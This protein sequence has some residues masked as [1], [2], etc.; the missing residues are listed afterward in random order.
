MDRLEALMKA[1][2]KRVV[3][4]EDRSEQP[5]VAMSQAG[6]TGSP[7]SAPS[8]ARGVPMNPVIQRA[9]D[10]V[11]RI[12]SG[13]FGGSVVVDPSQMSHTQRVEWVRRNGPLPTAYGELEAS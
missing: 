12:E 11:R 2:D 3:V 7:V 13:G 8:P 1:L 4:L 5:G 6:P 10:Q 9:M